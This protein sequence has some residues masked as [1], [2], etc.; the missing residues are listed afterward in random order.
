MSNLKQSNAARNTPGR[1]VRSRKKFKL[2]RKVL[3]QPAPDFSKVAS[4]SRPTLTDDVMGEVRPAT[5]SVE[6]LLKGY[7]SAILKSR[8][9]GKPVSFRVDVDP[10]GKTVV[11][12]FEPITA[13]QKLPSE[14][15]PE[16]QAALS[17]ARERG[18]LRAADILDSEDMLSADAF[19]RLLRTTRVTINAKRQSGQVLGLDGAKRGFRYPTWQL[20][21][22]GRPFAELE[23]LHER[24]GGPW[25]VYRFLVQ[26][27]GELQGLSGLE[28]L[29]LGQT[30]DVFE[31]VESMG[32]DFR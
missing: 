30:S 8:T 28:A 20:N 26:P 13:A 24:L 15:D 22:E 16:L 5:Q 4:K 3:A 1:P 9:I 18:R 6:L 27:H 31:A 19:A 10:N 23:A 14:S 17:A 21:I 12:R 29:E 32:R 2:A 7:R 11:T 25:A